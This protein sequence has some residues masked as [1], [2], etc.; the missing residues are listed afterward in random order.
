MILQ[1]LVNSF[2]VEVTAAYAVS[3]RLELYMLVPLIAVLQAV[4][5]YAGQNYGAQAYDRLITGMRQAVFLNIAIIGIMGT[6]GFVTAP[7]LVASFGISET[8]SDYAVGVHRPRS[9]CHLF[10]D[11]RVMPWHRQKLGASCGFNR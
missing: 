10:P 5:T 9:L 8:A 6:I 3:G 11:F 4:S 2:G 7:W 1:N